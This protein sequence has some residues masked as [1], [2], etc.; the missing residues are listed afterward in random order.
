MKTTR[1]LLSLILLLAVNVAVFAQ[2]GPKIEF[3]S[4]TVDYGTVVKG[5]DSGLRKFTFT[6]TGDAPLIIN[7]VNSTCGCTIPSS[8][9]E[10]ILPGKSGEI[11]V[12][13]SMR[14][15]PI[16]KT[17]T[18]ESNAINY[19]EGRIALNIRGLVEEKKE[20]TPAPEAENKKVLIEGFQDKQ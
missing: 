2:K 14:P 5:E 6:N 15:G 13:Y 7:K 3:E 9:K 10:P 20:E 12:K 4:T 17:I 1:T 8:P 18:V 11:E 16:R 19:E